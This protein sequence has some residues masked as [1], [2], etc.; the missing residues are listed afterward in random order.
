MTALGA[1]DVSRRHGYCN[2]C[3]QPGFPADALLGVDGWMTVRARRMACNA[4]LHGPFRKAE[5]LLRE[6][7]GWR[8]CPEKI[9][10][11]IHE[12]ATHLRRQ[13]QTLRKAPEA[14]EQAEGQE[15]EIHTD[16]GK[17]NTP[18]GWRDIKVA[19]Y[20]TRPRGESSGVEDY[21]QHALPS[22]G[23]RTV[24]AEV[25][26]AQDFGARCE[27]EAMR[28][29]LDGDSANLSVLG[30]GA[31]W[32]WNLAERHFWEAEQVLDIFHGVEKLAE[33]GR[34]AFGAGTKEMSSWL[35]RARV[36]LVG[37]G[38]EGVCE[39]LAEPIED[40]EA[41]ER[42]CVKSPEILNYFCGHRDRLGY[43][44]RLVRG[45]A[46]GSGLV[47]GTIKQRINV[48]MKRG[49]ARWLPQHVG[50]FV[51]MAA[52]SD[53]GEWEEYWSTMTL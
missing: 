39:M 15:C 22:H 26:T 37:D 31:E 36:K 40:E 9:R 44:V 24:V 3:G 6:L 28:L 14:F 11:C 7:C 5:H 8:V 51:E 52:L 53:T 50:P 38:Y 43:M 19:A 1:V 45:Q 27:R 32:I 29:G 21:E 4:G 46:I 34:E 35:E 41:R 49:S 18:E 25:E 48:R 47:E 30:D 42:F 2:A 33:L 12:Q 23:V 10:H 17:V 13:R 20:A 16:A